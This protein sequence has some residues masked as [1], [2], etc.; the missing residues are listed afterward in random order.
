VD[1]L[2]DAIPC[3]GAVDVETAQ[4]Y[5]HQYYV[6]GVSPPAMFAVYA[7]G[8]F[9]VPIANIVYTGVAD[10]ALVRA[11]EYAKGGEGEA[12]V[13]LYRDVGRLIR[14]FFVHTSLFV[15]GFASVTLR[16]LFTASCL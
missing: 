12:L 15:M 9:Q 13:R 14:S 10:V 16:P 8:C 6:A 4:G 7:V 11:T 2:R 1:L 3:G 5:L